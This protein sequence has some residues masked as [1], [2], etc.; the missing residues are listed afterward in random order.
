MFGQGELDEDAVDF[1][2]F[3]HFIDEGEQILLGS[4][5]REAII[6]GINA[7][8]G[9]GLFLCGNVRD[10]CGVCADENDTKAGGYAFGLEFFDL[11]F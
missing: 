9:A 11:G 8:F 2:V 1:R 4:L 5:G 6:I 7:D 3:V 10:T